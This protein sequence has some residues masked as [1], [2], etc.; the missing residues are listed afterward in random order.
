MA[1]AAINASPNRGNPSF[2]V[3]RDTNRI[4]TMPKY[5]AQ[6]F[7]DFSYLFVHI[8]GGLK[9]LMRLWLNQWIAQVHS[10]E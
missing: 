9:K 7:A 10:I 3:E 4:R 6:K 5:I 2:E 8:L 1:V